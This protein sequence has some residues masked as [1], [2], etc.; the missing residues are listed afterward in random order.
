M[1]AVEQTPPV[2]PFKHLLSPLNVRGLRLPNRV[3]M[4]AMHTRLETLNHAP[5]RIK[6]FYRARADGEVGLIITGGVAPNAE[7]RVEDGAP[8]LS[9][10]AD[11]AWHKA[12]VESVAGTPTLM[13][14]QIL[15]TGRYARF[16]G[17][18]APSAIKSRI[19]RYTPKALTT[20]EVW[21]TVGDY[22][23]TAAIAREV[24][25]H[26]VEIMG[27]EGYLINQFTA[28]VTN[29]RS[30]EF[31][32]SF[33]GRVRFPLE[34]LKAVRDRVGHDFPVIYRISALDLVDGGMPSDEI[35]SFAKLLDQGR[36]DILNT[37]IGWHESTVPT[38]AY[39]VPR[40]GWSYAVRRIKSF[41]KLPVV[42]SNRIND[43]YVAEEILASG[44]ADLVS[45]ARPLLADP[46]FVRKTREGRTKSINTCIACNQACLDRIFRKDSA[47]CLVNPRAAHEVEFPF[48]T[49]MCSKKIAV[50]GAGAAGIN[51]AFNAAERGHRVTLFEKGSC[52][53]GQLLMA[54]KV[55][56][57]I[58]FDEML[59]YFAQR[60]DEER[61]ELRMRCAPTAVELASVRYDA[62]IIATGVRPRV[63]DIPGIRHAK[64]LDYS[65]VLLNQR[66]VGKRVAIIGAGGIGFDM[67]EYLVGGA[68]HTPPTVHDFAKEYGLALEMLTPTEEHP[69]YAGAL[70]K[71]EVTLLQ[72]KTGRFGA[73]LSPSTGWILR[74]KLNRLGVQ[75]IGGVEYEKV[76]D[77]GLHIRVTGQARLL[78]VDSVIVCA[79]QE[80]ERGLAH[81]L[82]LLAP[83][84]PVQVIGGAD[85]AVELDAMRA[86]D[87][88]TRLA[89]TF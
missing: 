76:D 20:N 80:S 12:I 17:S 61:V 77:T 15:H 41:V 75:F 22:A 45:M 23:R 3:V 62:V 10:L 51:F 55:P 54:S 47:T 13:C 34:I 56:G 60:L 8:A 73:G 16:E 50:V 53:G 86:I 71:H 49:A 18:V 6:A 33:E 27:S 40:A 26:A 43:P 58:E 9:H 70:T 46:L 87:Q 38:I 7:G 72:R 24:G 74:D 57:K 30:D 14:L 11:A 69:V 88:A 4:G 32:G 52:I 83:D 48:G 42:A 35:L 79:G 78:E 19:S 66:A 84:L 63:P 25:Y 67:A 39:M 5:S 59:R 2:D 31:G 44:S 28:P 85:V 64:V 21:R 65:Q 29:H 89:M 68:P 1:P 82:R 36:C 81:E 37:G